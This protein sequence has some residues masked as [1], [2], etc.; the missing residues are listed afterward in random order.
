MHESICATQACA[1]DVQYYMIRELIVRYASITN[2]HDMPAVETRVGGGAS[3][4]METSLAG[5]MA[6][7]PSAPLLSHLSC[8]LPPA[9]AR[10]QG[11]PRR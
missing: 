2:Q 8:R 10:Q 3:W 1:L 5:L 6:R 11:E 9:S 7:L 4:Y